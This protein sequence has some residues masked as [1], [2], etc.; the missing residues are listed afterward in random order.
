MPRGGRGAHLIEVGLV[1]FT[2]LGSALLGLGGG[3]GGG[4]RGSAFLLRRRLPRCQA[5]LGL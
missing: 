4:R 5:F 3:N 1:L 2:L